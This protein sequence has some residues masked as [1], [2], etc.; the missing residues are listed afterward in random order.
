MMLLPIFGRELR[1]RARSRANYWTRVCVGLAAVL[2]CLESMQS[3]VFSTPNR[4]GAFVFNGIVAAA[5]LVSCSACLL[6]AD[7]ISAERREGTLSLL[8]L[9]HVRVLDVLIGKLGSVGIA[10][11]CGLLSFL[12][13]LMVPILAGGVTGGE[14]VRK[15]LGL[16]DGLFVA[17]VIG[18]FSSAA[19]QERFRAV[20]TA[21]LLLGSVIVL[22]FFAYVGWG[23]GL[24]FYF[25][26]FSPLVLLL[27]AGDLAY[28][29]SPAP[30]W[31]SLV[32]VQ[33]FGWGLLAYTGVR[34]RRAVTRDG[35]AY[36]VRPLEENP[37]AVGLGLWQPIKAETPPV[38]WLVYRQSGVHAAIWGVAV[39]ALAFNVWLPVVR[40][41]QGGSAGPFAF[42]A[43]SSLGT[44]SGLIGASM[45]AWI[46]SR[47]FLAV[48]RSGDLELLLTT[49]VGADTTVRDQ[50][51]VLKRLFVWP[52]LCMQAPLLPQL[53]TGLSPVPGSSVGGF[54]ADLL[55]LKLLTVANAFFGT[56]ALCWLGLWFGLRARS[57]SGAIVW[58]V[59]LGKGL[60]ILLGLSCSLLFGTTSSIGALPRHYVLAWWVPELFALAYYVVMAVG[61]RQWLASDLQ[62]KPIL[63][64][65][66]AQ[67]GN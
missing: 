29:A 57:L 22:P 1:A 8:F 17:L 35:G 58:T 36:D 45:L 62:G 46:A 9:T 10:G 2:V 66:R 25:G 11:L 13:V 16:L 47:F 60:P 27:R 20:R 24:F 14:A 50:W 15:G 12:P 43:A 42:A 48:R 28:S 33:A 52:V 37:R 40:Q 31:C 23:H 19:E 18:L 54:Q 56:A 51:R 32:V 59:G 21:L 41:A 64:P 49:P 67:E 7:A 6:S 55:L 34:L 39:L 53:L 3:S 65:R 30:F 26:L 63:L 61:A 38:E 44:V 4:M 5:F